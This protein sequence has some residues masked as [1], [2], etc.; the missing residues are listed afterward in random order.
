[1]QLR[2]TF[3]VVTHLATLTL[4]KIQLAVTIYAGTTS[5]YLETVVQ[6]SKLA[7]VTCNAALHISTLF[8]PTQPWIQA[9]CFELLLS[10]VRLPWA[11]S[12]MFSVLVM[13][14]WFKQGKEFPLYMMNLV[15]SALLHYCSCQLFLSFL[16]IH[17]KLVF[18]SFVIIHLCK[19]L[20]C[21]RVWWR[22][23]Q[24]ISCGKP[25]RILL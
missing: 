6:M 15:F 11:M 20:I 23:K 4:Y 13:M 3:K 22:E 12:A 5:F 7:Y 1:M 17:N 25:T 16:S 24:L 10:V 18:C 21:F 2:S 9:I 8:F 19:N 14:L